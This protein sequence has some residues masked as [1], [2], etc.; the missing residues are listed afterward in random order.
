MKSFLLILGS[1]LLLANSCAQ[2][3][4]QKST[5]TLFLSKKQITEDFNLIIQ[6]IEREVPY[7]FITA[8][9]TNYQ[10]VKN[11]IENSIKERMSIRDVYRMFYPLIQSLHDAHFALY[12]G[13]VPDSILYF[14]YKITINNNCIY[15]NESLTPENPI[16]AGTEIR[17]I[18][19]FSSDSIIR[20]IKGSA[21]YNREQQLFF[22]SRTAQ[23][24]HNRLYYLF[25]MQDSFIVQTDNTV[26]TVKGVGIEKF[27]IENKEQLKS[28][29]IDSIAYLKINSLIINSE[30]D[31]AT[32][33]SHL[34]AFFEKVAK[35]NVDKLIIDIRGNMGG[36]SVMAKDILDYI[37]ADGYTLS[38]GSD[39]FQDGL[40]KRHK[41]TAKH[42]PSPSLQ[43]RFKGK[44]V[45]LSD[46]LT[47]SSAH[48]M[49][50][51][52]QHF[53]MGVVIGNGST[54]ALHISGE[55]RKTILKNTRFELITP[56]VNFLLPGFTGVHN[57]QFRPDIM[58]ET[59][60]SY[61]PTST[62]IP[63]EKALNYL[64]KNN[65]HN[66]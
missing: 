65:F 35:E 58:V 52:F 40:V 57:P 13:N 1:C 43:N 22:E 41:N 18:N 12:P 6:K 27:T 56:V 59:K 31:R 21:Y 42:R 7:P 3:E 19:N 10:I 55:I 26:Q 48:M 17:T 51:G 29:I 45:L 16:P 25:G 53:K 34:N 60:D 49:Q 28:E 24:F 4:A 15:V 38:E 33:K 64:Q 20:V 37:T 39:Y 30:E 54:Q 62:D 9:K 32:F 50:A 36:S 44:A 66:K 47:Y 46:V 11:H 2:K 14:P 5:T 23:V 63:V 61:L 8:D